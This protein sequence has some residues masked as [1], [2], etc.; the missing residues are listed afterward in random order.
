MDMKTLVVDFFQHKKYLNSNNREHQIKFL[1]VLMKRYKNLEVYG[2]HRN[3]QHSIELFWTFSENGDLVSESLD[4]DFYEHY[5]SKTNN[6]LYRASVA[7]SDIGPFIKIDWNKLER[8]TSNGE[9]TTLF[10]LD[11]AVPVTVRNSLSDILGTTIYNQKLQVLSD[12][13]KLERLDWLK[14]TSDFEKSQYLPTL[15][16]LLFGGFQIYSALGI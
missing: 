14:S 8:S 3:Y 12:V 15:D 1:E 6:K 4:S 11:E 7:I 5:F 16:D 9:H 2:E 10:V 13:E